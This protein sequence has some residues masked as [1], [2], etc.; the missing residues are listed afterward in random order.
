MS[1]ESLFC[2]DM[3]DKTTYSCTDDG[4]FVVQPPLC[5]FIDKLGDSRSHALGRFYSLERR[6]NENFILKEMY[7]SF[8]NEYEQMGHMTLNDIQHT[9]PVIQDDL[10]G[11]LLSFRQFNGVVCADTEKMYRI[12]WLASEQRCL[13]KILWRR[14]P[15]EDVQE[16]TLNTITYGTR[17]AAYLAIRCLKQLGL[18][19][20]EAHPEASN[21]ILHGFYVDDML[22]GGSYV[23]EMI[24]VCKQ[25]KEILGGAGFN[26]K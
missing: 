26:L 15:N 20:L 17:S 22:C 9:G 19:N 18:D 21:V 2:E 16:Y 14:K 24:D 6:L 10:L 3:F 11:I 8:M 7:F 23:T 13:Q 1:K 25:V 12:V 5:D 4:K